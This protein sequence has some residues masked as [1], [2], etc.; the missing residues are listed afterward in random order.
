MDFQRNRT[1]KGR[2]IA[3]AIIGVLVLVGILGARRALWQLFPDVPAVDCR[4]I[5]IDTVQRGE[6]VHEIRCVGQLVST[7]QIQRPARTDARVQRI[8]E[9]PGVRVSADTLLVEL[10][11]PDLERDLIDARSKLSE[12]E[13]TLVTEEARF[14][15]D[16][17]QL[18]AAWSKLQYEHDVARAEYDVAVSLR[19]TNAISK[20]ETRKRKI[21]ADG[22]SSQKD[23]AKESYERFTG[24]RV[25]YLA[26]YSERIAQARTGVAHAQS[27][28]AAL[29]VYA[30][31]E[32]VLAQVPVKAGQ[33][34][35]PGEMV[36]KIVDP[37]QLK[38]EL[39]VAEVEA[40][41]IREGQRAKI[42]TRHG[43]ITG[44]VSRV[45]PEVKEGSVTID[46]VFNAEALPSEARP[47]LTVTGLVEVNRVEDVLF[48]GRPP[49]AL[50]ESS[51]KLFACK[52]DDN[53]K[54]PRAELKKVE[55]G[56]ASANQIVIR[57]G[58]S[59]G[60]R[61]I[62]WDLSSLGDATE[63]RLENY[64]SDSGT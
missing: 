9:L 19:T 45:E 26:V 17:L 28:L 25:N 41:Y 27:L 37:K 61:V 55:F 46:V 31:V 22:L 29:N 18:K 6:F 59:E 34:L 52:T 12:A 42:D 43:I 30:G 14:D 2:W 4:T 23:T 50:S 48:V 7:V 32:G 15:R 47:D 49:A 56:M 11:N 13:A 64:V 51:G 62:V 1:S 5:V 21:V 44:T 24:S 40:R 60:D 35:A 33:Q 63:V 36:A 58:L 38:A 8:V 57:S 3:P 10:A 20:Q 54:L 39:R 16:R 53:A